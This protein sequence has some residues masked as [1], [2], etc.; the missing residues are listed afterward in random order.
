MR[1]RRGMTLMELIVGLVLTGMMA[2]MGAAAF[3]SIIEH[4]RV[5]QSSTV[6]MERAAALRETLR[7][8][9]ADGRVAIQQGGVPR[10]NGGAGSATRTSAS[11]S[12]GTAAVSAAAASGDEITFTTSAPNPSMA[13]SVRIRLFIDADAGTP[14]RGLTIEYQTSAALPLQRLQ[15]DSTIGSM[16]VEFLDSRTQRWFASSEAATISPSAFRIALFPPDGATLPAILQL[17]LIFRM[18]GGAQ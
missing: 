9:L 15:L 4:R 2:T 17:P 1:N 10:I 3:G 5:I 12:S 11:S 16:T 18:A 13:P 8:W 6:D 7:L 14:E